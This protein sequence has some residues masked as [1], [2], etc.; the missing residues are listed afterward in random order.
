MGGTSNPIVRYAFFL[1]NASPQYNSA[2]S[3]IS[4]NSI[5]TELNLND[6]Q[7]QTYDS[8]NLEVSYDFDFS[9]FKDDFQASIYDKLG[10]NPLS[11]LINIE[12]K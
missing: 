5:K 8:I 11:F 10:D 2:T 7:L 6:S 3:T 1:D 9:S 4:G 12:V